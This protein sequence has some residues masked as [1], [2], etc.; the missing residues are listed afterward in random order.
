MKSI[1]VTILSLCFAFTIKSQ[2][3]SVSGNVKDV[4]S[5]SPIENAKVQIKNINN[6]LIDS[7]FSDVIGNWQ[8]DM[9]NIG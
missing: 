8:Y 7:V 1:S 4:K 5:N 3:I 9:A 6:G 2:T